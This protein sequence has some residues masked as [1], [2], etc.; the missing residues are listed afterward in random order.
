MKDFKPQ[1]IGH[2]HEEEKQYTESVNAKKI[3][4]NE[5]FAY[6]NNNYIT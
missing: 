6:L 3:R 5:L 1:V 4:F 2:N